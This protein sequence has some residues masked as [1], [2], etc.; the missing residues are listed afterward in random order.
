MWYACGKQNSAC[1]TCMLWCSNTE[2]VPLSLVS[3]IHDI[4][5]V[6]TQYV[7]VC[8]GL[9]YYAFPVPVCTKYVP[10]RT[11]SEPVRTKLE[12]PIPVMR[13]T[14]PDASND[15]F[16]LSCPPPSQAAR[17]RDRKGKVCVLHASA[18]Y[19][20]VRVRLPRAGPAASRDAARRAWGN[21]SCQCYSESESTQAAA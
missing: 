6:C 18:P 19:A 10:V 14:I 1:V 8:T 7:L 3:I 13:F 9:Y 5:L 21:P 15:P 20:S 17:R 2:K 16:P 12:Y 4:I 11:D